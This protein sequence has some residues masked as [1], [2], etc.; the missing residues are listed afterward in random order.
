MG[1]IL[2]SNEF[3]PCK[4]FYAST[5]Y[6]SNLT[7]DFTAPISN[8]IASLFFFNCFFSY[9]FYS[10]SYSFNSPKTYFCSVFCL[11]L[12]Y[13]FISYYVAMCFFYFEI[14]LYTLSTFS[15]IFSFSS[16]FVGFLFVFFF[17]LFCSSWDNS[18]RGIFPA[19]LLWE[20]RCY[21]STKFELWSSPL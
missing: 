10:S 20:F 8:E 21:L 2:A 19:E 7:F 16:L 17:Y 18:S 6:L 1:I 14:N 12:M 4:I 13:S 9:L 5:L 3:W 11:E 15:T